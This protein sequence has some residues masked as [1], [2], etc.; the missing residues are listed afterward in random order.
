MAQRTPKKVTTAKK[1]EGAKSGPGV[2]KQW[3]PAQLAVQAAGRI[4]GDLL[5]NLQNIRKTFLKI[6]QLLTEVRDQKHYLTL[7]HPDMAEYALKRLEMSRTAMY[8]YMQV[9]EW[10][11]AKHPEWLNPTKKKVRIPE[12]TQV[13]GAMWAAQELAKEDLEPERKATLE[14]LEKKA[15]ARKL[16]ARELKAV[17]QRTNKPQPNKGT[18][19]LLA[20]LRTLRKRGER[21][22]VSAQLIAAI[23]S[24]I[25]VAEHDLTIET[26]GMH[27]LDEW[28]G[29][30]CPSSCLG[31]NSLLA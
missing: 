27:Y 16:T 7:H 1:K 8:K 25:R 11:R 26:A 3:S 4:T 21:D 19:K 17:Q 20:S 2:E 10:A 24:A 9:Y 28:L 30:R 14:A 23:D 22:G 5:N 31:R 6:G 15:L 13:V 18:A 12:L 29:E